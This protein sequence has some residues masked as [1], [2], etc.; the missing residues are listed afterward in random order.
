MSEDYSIK[1]LA[2]ELKLVMQP[3]YLIRKRKR[4]WLLPDKF[5]YYA[6]LEYVKSGPYSKL[7]DAEAAY[8]Q[9]MVYFK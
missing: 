8:W 5:E 7:E 2:G 1:F 9:F 6:C 4:R 3:P